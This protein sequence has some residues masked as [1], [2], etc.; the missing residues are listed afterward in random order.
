M[1]GTGPSE[2]PV[3]KAIL[4]LIRSLKVAD[5]GKESIIN[6]CFSLKL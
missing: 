1:C 6:S 3:L 5:E 4:Y 2:T